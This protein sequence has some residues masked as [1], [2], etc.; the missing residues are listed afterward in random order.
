MSLNF[1]FSFPLIKKR[2][3]LIKFN[4]K[5]LTP[6]LAGLKWVKAHP[7]TYKKWLQGVATVDG[8][9]AVPAFEAYLGSKM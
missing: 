3:S 9:P 5:S 2:V 6:R 1:S 7:E 8:K 4:D